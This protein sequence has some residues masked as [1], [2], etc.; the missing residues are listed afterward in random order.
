MWSFGVTFHPKKYYFVHL[1]KKTLRVF[2]CK[3]REILQ[4][5]GNNKIRKRG[6]YDTAHVEDICLECS[7]MCY[8]FDA[9]NAHTISELCNHVCLC[10]KICMHFSLFKRQNKH[11]RFHPY[12][13][14]AIGVSNYMAAPQSSDFFHTINKQAQK[15]LLA[16]DLSLFLILV[17]SLSLA[18]SFIRTFSCI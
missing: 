14:P 13:F 11:S 8:I 3:I 10:T 9:S 4:K 7:K 6:V 2:N 1:R 5:K 17:H 15:I 12:I 16:I 18:H